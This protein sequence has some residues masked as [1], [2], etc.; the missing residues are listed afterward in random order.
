[1]MKWL[2]AFLLI[3][4]LLALLPMVFADSD[5]SGILASSNYDL[6]FWYLNSTS[7][8]AVTTGTCVGV[9]LYPNN[10][11]QTTLTFTHFGFGFWNNT[12]AVPATP[13]GVY[14]AMSNCT[15]SGLENQTFQWA[16]L[17]INPLQ[18]TTLRDIYSVVNATN[19]TAS[20]INST[21]NQI[22][23]SNNAINTTNYAI[24]RY[25]IDVSDVKL[26]AI[27]NALY[28]NFTYILGNLSSMDN[29]MGGNFTATNALINAIVVNVTV[30]VTEN[31]TTYN[32]TTTLNVSNGTTVLNVTT[33]I[34][35]VDFTS[36]NSRIDNGFEDMKRLLREI[37]D[38]MQKD[39]ISGL[40][41]AI[42]P[43]H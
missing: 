5:S 19:A 2:Y 12:W 34:V 11:V 40:I 26:D 33:Q 24:Y 25:L 27:R 28:G 38:K 9:M 39:P 7:N 21:V 29:Y 18:S 8:A 23:A 31:V 1:M 42:N 22:N 10:S 37:L 15:V 35:N 13:L 36:I 17:V 14:K 3:L 30:N 4:I 20:Q 16:G 32:Y 41:S 43:F 6:G